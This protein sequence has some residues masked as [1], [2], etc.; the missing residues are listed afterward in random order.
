MRGITIGRLWGIPIRIHVSLLVVLPLLAWLLGSGTQIAVYVDLINTLWPGRLDPAVFEA[1]DRSWTIGTLAAVGLFFSVAVHEFGHA[2]MARRYGIETESITLW[3][4]GG[5]ASLRSFPKE[6]NREF[7][8]AI[9]GP[10]TSVLLAGV[11]VVALQLVPANQPVVLFLLGWL[12]I[13]NIALTVFNL[14]PAFPMDGGRVLRALLASQRSY[15]SATRIAARIGT[16]FAILFAVVGVF[17]LNPILLLVAL[18]VYSAATGESRLVTLEELLG[19]LTVGDLA[20]TDAAVS[21]A[22][23]ASDLFDQLLATRRTDVLVHDSEG[24]I[25]GV[26][27]AESLRSVSS[28]AYD[29]TP[30]E[31]LMTSDLPRI[32]RDL[33]AFEGVAALGE[34]RAEIALVEANGELVGAFST[35]DVAA[36]LR[37]QSRVVAQ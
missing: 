12:A 8:I 28:S 25:V 33:S 26:V 23:T 7:W 16:I 15:A 11:C 18:F 32:S 22:D 35:G 37:L 6:W 9:A 14:L 30:V 31:A 3:I 17:L 13:T 20:R 34:A 2:L 1:A 21:T 5:L 36:A 4:L 29:T 10:A 19:G 27:T 24:A